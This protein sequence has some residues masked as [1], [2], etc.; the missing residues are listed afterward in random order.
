MAKVDGIAS[1]W[2]CT[3]EY[4]S[5]CAQQCR[6][7]SFWR[8][9]LWLAAGSA[10]C[11]LVNGTV[12]AANLDNCNHT[13]IRTFASSCVAPDLA[14]NE[15]IKMPRFGDDWGISSR[16]LPILIAGTNLEQ[17]YTVTN[18]VRPSLPNKNDR[19]FS[20]RGQIIAR[21]PIDDQLGKLRLR[22]LQKRRVTPDPE[23]GVLRV[24]E[25]ELQRQPIATDS[26]LGTLRVRP[27][28][29]QP[30]LPDVGQ[31][32]FEP[33]TTLQLLAQVGYFQ[34][35]NIFSGV[36]PVSGG[37]FSAGL[38][39]VGGYSISPRTSLIATI[40][41]NLINYTDRSEFN[42]NQFRV[43]A[44]IRHQLTPRV[45]GEVNWINQQLF[46]ASGDR[47][48]NENALRFLLRR[49]D[50]LSDDLR[51]DT[52]YELRLNDA[53]PES[54]SRVINSLGVSLN[55][56][57]QNNLQAGLDYQLSVVDFTERLREDTYQRLLARLTYALNRDSQLSVQGGWT[58]GDST[59][60]DID[61]DNLFFSVTYTVE[62]ADF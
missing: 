23:L 12:F 16:K 25:L 49:R 28:E 43:R 44:G 42:Y 19:H 21:S 47:F 11:C 3:L 33:N 13:A 38:T 46:R 4:W 55:Y 24:R 54:R 1:Q 45:L 62:L 40:D 29:E 10:G 61:F 35:N 31:Q 36:D 51:I 2:Q 37:L 53:N 27:L 48:L 60:A 5:F 30:T 14:N 20:T 32:R 15:Q 8:M 17:L 56:N 22:E 7:G 39:L 58:F 34:T 50:A 6:F 26:D 18:I 41:G 59:D 9:R 57:I 52:S